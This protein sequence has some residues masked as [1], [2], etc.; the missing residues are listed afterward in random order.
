MNCKKILV[1]LLIILLTLPSFCQQRFKI[2]SGEDDS[3]LPYA[4]IVNFTKKYYL[5]A[6]KTGEAIIDVLPGDSI[7]ISYVGYKDV[8]FNDENCLSL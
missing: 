2:I 6:S 8:S 1:L 7:I 3:P 5:S 4:T